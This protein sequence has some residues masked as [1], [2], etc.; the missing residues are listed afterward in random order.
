MIEKR[1][2]AVN[3]ALS[4]EP[5]MADAQIR[6]FLILPKELN[7]DDGELTRTQKVRRG[8]IAERYASLI[9]GLCDGASEASISTEITYEDGR[10]GRL[11]ANGAHHGLAALPPG[12][13]APCSG[14]KGK[15]SA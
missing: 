1:V 14:Q 8:I 7:P 10:K 12:Q 11:E 13:R 9:D 2:D 6:R 4:V 15:C 5:I 3:R